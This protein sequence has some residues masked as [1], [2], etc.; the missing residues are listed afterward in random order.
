MWL[1]FQLLDK[2]VL[3]WHISF[4]YALNEDPEFILLELL[5]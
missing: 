1:I 3:T 5:E 4:P 2:D